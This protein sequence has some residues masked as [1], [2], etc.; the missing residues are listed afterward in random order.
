M[1]KAPFKLG[2]K[3]VLLWQGHKVALVNDQDVSF[4]HLLLKNVE[5][6][7]RKDF[8]RQQAQ[9]LAS[10][11]RIEHH[12][13]RGDAIFVPVHAP[14]GITH[15][16]TKVRATTHR[17]GDE[18]LWL[19]VRGQLVGCLAQGVELATEA[20]SGDFFSGKAMGPKHGGIDQT[21]TL[22]IGDQADAQPCGLPTPS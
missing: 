9:H 20:T 3:L 16:G 11:Q 7:R 15:A 5:D 18:D 22:V 1:R 21:D 8:A 4:F 10:T 2:L 6:F 17:L 13:Q 19:N 12:A 14:Q